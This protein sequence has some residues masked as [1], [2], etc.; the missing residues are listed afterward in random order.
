MQSSTQH[1]H[2]W[3]RRMIWII[4]I[5]VSSFLRKWHD[6]LSLCAMHFYYF[7][8]HINR[9]IWNRKT[10][11]EV[12]SFKVG[13]VD[14]LKLSEVACSLERLSPRK[15]AIMIIIKALC[16]KGKEKGLESKSH[17]RWNSIINTSVKILQ[18]VQYSHACVRVWEKSNRGQT[19]LWLLRDGYKGQEIYIDKMVLN[20]RVCVDVSLVFKELSE[21]NVFRSYFLSYCIMCVAGL[22]CAE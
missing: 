16:V 21:M 11:Y 18:T 19:L 4:I 3:K 6:G 15:N 5:K 13:Q 10:C 14:L 22:V 12:Q 17:S 20:N 2:Y 1:S 9:Y 7:T 8:S